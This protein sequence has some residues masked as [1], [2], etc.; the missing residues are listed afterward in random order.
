MADTKNKLQEKQEILSKELFTYSN[1]LKNVN[2]L[3]EIRLHKT[4]QNFFRVD[5]EAMK[6]VK[7]ALQKYY[8]KKV[9]AAQ[10]KLSKLK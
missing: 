3:S 6:L 8:T 4:P 5:E 9:N 1:E 10:L 7:A 2:L